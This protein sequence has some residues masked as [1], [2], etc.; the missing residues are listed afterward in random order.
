MSAEQNFKVARRFAT[1]SGFLF[2]LVIGSS[3]VLLLTTHSAVT[4][5]VTPFL[6][7]LTIIGPIFS[8]L[9][10]H[11]QV[12]GN[13]LLRESQFRESF[14][15]PIGE[16]IRVDYYN[17][18]LKPSIKRLGATTLENTKFTLAVLGGMLWKIRVMTAVY[19][20]VFI[21]LVSV[22]QT[23][24][25]WVLLATQSIF[26]GDVFLRWVNTERFRARTYEC[27]SQLKQHFVEAAKKTSPVT[28]AIVLKAFANY[29][30][31]KDEFGSPLCQKNFDQLNPTVTKEWEDERAELEI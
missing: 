19:L 23:D 26:S 12:K 11:F 8:F 5:I 14:D 31:A 1:A 18:K 6:V 15:V 21:L 4:S 13:S 25:G 7:G 10:R 17:T 3:A 28:Y 24:L 20:L 16:A 27:R 22:R 9:L 2:L 30:C 29:E